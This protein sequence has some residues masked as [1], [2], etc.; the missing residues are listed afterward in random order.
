MTVAP[1]ERIAEEVAR[2]VVKTRRIVGALGEAIRAAHS[3]ASPALAAATQA[4]ENLY[5]EIEAEFGLLTSAQAGEAM[6]SRS[7][8]KRNLASAAYRD[9]RLLA[10]RRGNY[11]LYPA[12]Q[13][14][15]SGLRPVIADLIA[16]GRQHQR[17]SA[18]IIQWL[19]A[20]TTYLAGRRPVDVI[21]APEQLLAAAGDAFGVQW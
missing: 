9:G 4:R 19:M 21:D 8:A 12:F 1:E 2:E 3:T 5:D 16:L 13:F 14:S 20:P 17:T 6:G 10:L 18:G 15:E 11:M 7:T